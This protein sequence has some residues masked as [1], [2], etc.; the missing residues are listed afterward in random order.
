LSE[1]QRDEIPS[2]FKNQLILTD[3]PIIK[4]AYGTLRY[5]RSP[6]LCYIW[7]GIDIT[8]EYLW[9]AYDLTAC[10]SISELMQLYRDLGETLER[11]QKDF[12]F[13]LSK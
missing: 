5:K 4:D 2:V 13:Y 7:I 1:V 6:L 12:S 10:F 9:E 8:I 11:F 3:H